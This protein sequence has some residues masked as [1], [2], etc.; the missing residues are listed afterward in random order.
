[1]QSDGM[2]AIM[3]SKTNKITSKWT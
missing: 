2:S 1:M 3:K